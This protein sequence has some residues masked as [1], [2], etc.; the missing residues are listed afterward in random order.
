MDNRLKEKQEELLQE[1]SDNFMKAV[2]LA[3]EEETIREYED[4]LIE[5]K[6]L[7][8]SDDFHKK[9][10][11][12]VAEFE[13]KE[14]RKDWHKK[15]KA[16]RRVAAIFVVCLIVAVTVLTIN[17]DAFRI[18]VFDFFQ[19]D[20]GNYVEI[21]PTEVEE[22]SE[23]DRKKL[24]K[25]WDYVYYPTVLPDGYHLEEAKDIAGIISLFFTNMENDILK[26]TMASAD[27]VQTN[28]DSE[29][30]EILEVEVNGIS[31]VAYTSDTSNYIIWINTEYQIDL[32]SDSIT[33]DEMLKIA[34]NIEKLKLKYK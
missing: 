15:T 27:S 12:M 32:Y 13:T 22:I 16:F 29:Y 10:Q 24:P 5:C 17:V 1:R 23:A 19:I 26:L 28:L 8:P 4:A 14:Q 7:E 30:G 34:E 25:E 31:G 9:M 2:A 11:V 20:H 3:I 6:D 33:L 21:N 18:K